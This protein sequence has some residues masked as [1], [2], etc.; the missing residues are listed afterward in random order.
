MRLLLVDDDEI[1]RE[2]LARACRRRGHEVATAADGA[3]AQAQLAS[4]AAEACVLDLR[5]ASESGLNLVP[6]LLACAPRLNILML[7]GYSSIA[8]AVEA[9][10]RGAVNYLAKPATADDIL[11]AL[12]EAEA[13]QAEEVAA[14]LDGQ[15]LSVDRLAWEHIQRVLMEEGGNISSTARRLGM[16]RRTLQRRLLKRPVSQ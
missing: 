4:F 8:T 7:T 9:I 13:G 1:F 6:E 12:G 2:T 14:D 16:H 5:L 11:R 15:D 3:G 10:K